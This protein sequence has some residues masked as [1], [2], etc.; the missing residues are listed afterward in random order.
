[1]EA[2]KKK[3]RA[4]T[5]AYMLLRQRPRSEFEIRQRLKLKGYDPETIDEV[6]TGLVRLGEIDDAKFAKFWVD[7]RMRLNPAGDVVLRHE[8]KEKGVSAPIIDS[9]LE[10]RKAAYD[11]REVA[12]NMAREKFERLRKLDK[13]KA[14]KRLYDF[15][16]RRGFEFD[17][18]RSVVEEVSRLK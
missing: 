11:D 5:N 9:T 15:L 13:R 8:L 18:V 7:S 10:A 1:M 6:I 2:D 4:R 17:I 14:T 3:A 16:I 12:L